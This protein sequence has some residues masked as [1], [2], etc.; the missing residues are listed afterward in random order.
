MKKGL[1]L[2][3]YVQLEVTVLLKGA[4]DWNKQSFVNRSFAVSVLL[5]SCS[6]SQRFKE[7]KP[8]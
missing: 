1:G 3:D 8:H 7:F 5:S 6:Q 4:L 2:I